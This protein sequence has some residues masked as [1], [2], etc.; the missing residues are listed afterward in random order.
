MQV[1]PGLSFGSGIVWREDHSQNSCGTRL[2]IIPKQPKFAENNVEVFNQQ[3][4]TNNIK[5]HLQPYLTKTDT[6]D[7][8]LL[9]KV[10]IACT[11]EKE[12]QDKKRHAAPQRGTSVSTVQTEQSFRSMSPMMPVYLQQHPELLLE[13]R[14]FWTIRSTQLDASWGPRETEGHKGEGH[15]EGIVHFVVGQAGK[16]RRKVLN[17]KGVE[18][19]EEEED[20]DVEE[21]HPV[22][23][24]Q[25][26]VKRGWQRSM[27]IMSAPQT[28]ASKGK[29]MLKEYVGQYIETEHIFRWMTSHLARRIKTVRQSAQLV[30]EWHSDPAHPIKMFLFTHLSQ[31]PAFFSSLSV[32]FTGRIEFIFVDVRH[33]DNRSTLLDIGVTQSPSYILKMPEGIYHY[34]NSTGEFLS[35]AAMDTFLRSVQPEVNDLF[36]LSLVLINLLAWMDFFITQYSLDFSQFDQQTELLPVDSVP[37]QTQLTREASKRRMPEQPQLAPLNIKEQWLYSEFLPDDRDSHPISKGEPSTLE[38]KPI[39]ASDIVGTSAYLLLTILQCTAGAFD[40]WM[41]IARCTANDAGKACAHGSGS[42]TSLLETG[43]P[44]FHSGISHCERRQKRM[45]ILVPPTSRRLYIGVYPGEREGSL[46]PLMDGGTGSDCCL[47]LRVKQKFRLPT[48]FGVL[49]GG[50]E[51]CPSWGNR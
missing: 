12:R 48:L 43:W 36:V 40:A 38:R 3:L 17:N 14:Q 31:P 32:K 1:S 51:E 5:S 8:L 33:W 24:H 28:S 4:T 29:V 18:Q 27:I 11:K 41:R 13:Y 9:E 46:P 44:Y 15:W 42:G 23:F 2:L 7:E 50:T 45:G 21:Y 19:L 39:L 30:E 49:G 6:P 34:G 37:R 26:C 22:L 16:K 35:L 20:D 47:C 10:N 25:S